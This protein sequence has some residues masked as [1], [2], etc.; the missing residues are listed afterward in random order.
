MSYEKNTYIGSSGGSNIRISDSVNLPSS[1][2]CASSTAVKTAYDKALEA[3]TNGVPVGTIIWSA[4]NTIPSGYLLCNG[5]EVSRNTYAA[6]FTAIG[7][8]YGEGDGSTTFN[9]PNLI[10]KFIEGLATAGIE[11]EAGLPNITG[12]FCLC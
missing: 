1:D 3:I 8:T 10:G 6:L 11:H 2:T 5:V 12:H 4:N 7:T 9:L